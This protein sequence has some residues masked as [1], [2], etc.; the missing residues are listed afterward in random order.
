MSVM[1]DFHSIPFSFVYTT[2]KFMRT[3]VILLPSLLIACQENNNADHLSIPTQVDVT[4]KNISILDSVKEDKKSVKENNEAE[5]RYIPVKE[6]IAEPLVEQKEI[7]A[8]QTNELSLEHGKSPSQKKTKIKNSKVRKGTVL[9]SKKEDKKEVVVQK[10]VSNVEKAQVQP[11]LTP[12]DLI[13]QGI[14]KT[15]SQIHSIDA[16]F[17]QT[18]HNEIL[19]QELIQNGSMHIMKP[20]L[21]LWDIQFPMEQRYYFD[22]STLRVWNPM[23]QQL[24]VSEN[25]GSEGDVAS[26]LSDLSSISKKYQ[27]HLISKTSRTIKLM[28][29]PNEETGCESVQLTM[30]A[31]DYH[32]N[33]LISRCSQTGDVHI[34]FGTFT[35]NT[36]T[37]PAIFQWTPPEGA[38]IISS[39]DLYD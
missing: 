33:D 12:L 38:E 13:L 31:K 18:I 36:R 1:N 7:V 39:T 9:Q 23:N 25:S 5:K 35:A 27:V 26:L 24:L 37:S 20:N 16:D 28:A 14:E 22:G 15:Y 19:D 32:L 30:S 2:E 29:Y 17:E 34:S 4:H 8:V 11:E 21:F 3:I 6:K 10:E